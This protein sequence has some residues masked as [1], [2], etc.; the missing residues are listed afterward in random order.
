[1]FSSCLRIFAVCF[2]L[3]LGMIAHP[4]YANGVFTI[5][6]IEVSG[7]GKD[8]RE[9]KDNAIASGEAEA[10]RRLVERL[11]DEESRS[12]LT[13]PSAQEISDMVQEVEVQHESITPQHYKADLSITFNSLFV[14]KR[15]KD[16]GIAY[17]T[18]RTDTIVVLPV[19]Q[20]GEQ[21]LLF[22]KENPW[23][24]A[25]DTVAKSGGFVHLVVPG[26]EGN[27]SAAIT[28]ALN[29]SNLPMESQPALSSLLT[30]Y[31][32]KKLL[33]AKAS[34]QGDTGTSLDIEMAYLGEGAPPP[35]SRHFEG[36]T[37]SAVMN[38]AVTSILSDMEK[39]WKTSRLNSGQGQSVLNLNVPISNLSQW[40]QM[41]AKFGSMPFIDKVN[42]RY[43]TVNFGSVDLYYSIGYEQLV[44][45]L[46]QYGI[47]LENKANGVFM[48]QSE[49]VPTGPQYRKVYQEAGYGF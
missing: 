9:A 43:V 49:A 40:K 23:K 13:T 41:L 14:E 2:F 38:T 12:R 7:Q 35:A 21:P 8:S 17:V 36:E 30:K 26:A 15:L 24:Q 33:L 34:P 31:R 4:A 16:A 32:G 28:A 46:S 47:T 45:S 29:D 18:K 25:W 10:Y 19:W 42:T 48:H 3:A 6:D 44:Q 1:M 22:E 20:A 37:Q 11:A 27:D 5:T 39:Q